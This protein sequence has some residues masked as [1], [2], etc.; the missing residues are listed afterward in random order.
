MKVHEALIA[1]INKVPNEIDEIQDA[2]EALAISLD[3]GKICAKGKS[4]RKKNIT[5]MYQCYKHAYHVIDPI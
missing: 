4:A 5:R 3:E 1:Q 2:T